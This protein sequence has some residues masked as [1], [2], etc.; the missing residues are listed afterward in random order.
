MFKF[1]SKKEFP[2]ATQMHSLPISY[3][4]MR[5]K[6]LLGEGFLGNV[7]VYRCVMHIIKAMQSINIQL[8]D[9]NG[10]EINSVVAK[11]VMTLLN[12]PN[13]ND[14]KASFLK[15]NFINYLVLGEMFCSTAMAGGVPKEL[16]T[17]SPL[18]MEVLPGKNVPKAYI[19][20]VQSK[21]VVFEVDQITGDSDMFFW[22][23]VNPLDKWRGMSPLFA[24]SLSA[25]ANTAGLRWNY[26]LLKNGTRGSGLLKFKGNPSEEIILKVRKYFKKF[27]QGENKAGEVPILTGDMEFQELGQN[28]K[29]MDFVLTLDKT[30]AFIAMAYGV[31]LPLVLTTAATFNNMSEAKE[32]LYTD[33]VIPLLEEFL[34][35]FGN[36]LLP[37]FGL[38]NARFKLDRDSIMALEGMR[39]RRRDSFVKTTAGGLTTPDEAREEIGFDP[40]GGA[41]SFLYMPASS[42]PIE[43]EA[44]GESE[45][46]KP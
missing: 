14:G 4:G 22:R 27:F 1:F 30:T 25:D 37:K 15:E 38:K 35:R 10:K 16:W 7:V 9:E 2:G 8:V 46:D 12:K 11:Q 26:S 34:N 3:Q 45:D 20:T 21:K 29:D 5:G 18:E 39:S 36:W 43:D 33:T 32:L 28:P 19:H 41:A 24:A 44:R 17:F 6:K 40:M 13:P 23:D 31:P 42:L